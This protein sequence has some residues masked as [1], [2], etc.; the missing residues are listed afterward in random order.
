MKKVYLLIA[1]GLTC[2]LAI[3]FFV[4]SVIMEIP[5]DRLSLLDENLT[6]R[7]FSSR[8]ALEE[9]AIINRDELKDYLRFTQD[10][11]DIEKLI[12]DN[13][14]EAKGKK[15]YI[16]ET[17]ELP[18][19]ILN[20]CLSLNCFQ[21]RMSFESIP[22]VF[23]KTLIAI[24]DQRFLN[25]QGIDYYSIL[26]ALYYDLKSLKIVQGGST[27]SQQLVKNLFLTNEKTIS[28]KIKEIIM[29][30][31]IEKNFSKEEILEAY[32]NEFEWGSLQGLKIKGLH[33]ACLYYFGKKPNEIDIFEAAILIG[34]L[35]GP[36]YYHP[37]KYEERLKS[38]T[39]VVF[40]KLIDLGF[41]IPTVNKQWTEKEWRSW[42]QNLQK[43]EKKL[44]L[45]VMWEIKENNFLGSYE[46][47]V[48]LK[49]ARDL[50]NQMDNKN[51]SI[52][53]V[54]GNIKD[55]T[56]KF[57]FY[58]REQRNK[59]RA[60]EEE[61]H[62]IGSVIK[63]FLYRILRTKFPSLEEVFL[64]DP[65]TLELK[66]GKWEPSEAGND[67]KGEVSLKEALLKSMNRPLIRAALEF[68]MK[69]LGPMLS[70]WFE[71]Y[72]PLQEYPSQILGAVEVSVEDLYRKYIRFFN[73]E[74]NY[75][76]VESNI[77]Y[78]LSD[79]TETTIRKKVGKYLKSHRFFGKTGT[80][81]KGLNN[82]FV[83]FDGHRVG[84]IWVGWEADQ[85]IKDLKLYG[86][87]TAFKLFQGFYLDN[88]LR[89]NDIDCL[90]T[91]IP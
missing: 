18:P 44:S 36:Y 71:I 4:I 28:R 89:F 26:R 82:W 24:E 8:S 88:G 42:F 16:N 80:T 14:L 76:P 87:T 68:D 49:K 13:K 50:E 91:A 63:P 20:D 25:H 83:F 48:F 73:E 40:K 72:T 61:K 12:D 64:K 77:I 81:N 65:L 85:D 69:E 53:A 59:K 1:S 5:S 10:S 74:C 7:T 57:S 27:I 9:G 78:L 34:L 45:S 67:Q 19:L 23:W 39:K 15:L 79:P 43:N 30:L 58:S 55:P 75:R 11:W 38:R 32:F 84:I 35:K 33:A 86:S 60:M 29:A 54:I 17:I 2:L 47:F 51:I 62:Q 66:S 46:S 31:Y 22:S 37:L 70:E 90:Q 56:H 21:H 6:K 41:A 52:K 3:I